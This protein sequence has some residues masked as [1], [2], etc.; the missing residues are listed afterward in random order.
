M[1]NICLTPIAL[2][3]ISCGFSG[4][5]QVIVDLLTNLTKLDIDVL[6]PQKKKEKEKEKEKNQVKF[7]LYNLIT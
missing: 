7:N 2:A 3:S 1:S 6:P 4:V 5:S